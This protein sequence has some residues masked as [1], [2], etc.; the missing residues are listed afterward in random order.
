MVLRLL[1]FFHDIFLEDLKVQVFLASDIQG[2]PPHFALDFSCSGT[3]AV[4]FW[5]GGGELNN[6]V[7]LIQFVSEFSQVG[8]GG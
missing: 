1:N 7:L 6:G 8:A 5:A 4:I 3:V 2:E